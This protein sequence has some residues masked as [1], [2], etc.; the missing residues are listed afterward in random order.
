MNIGGFGPAAALSAEVLGGLTGRAAIDRVRAIGYGAIGIPVWR[1][2]FAPDSLGDSGSRDLAA[3]LGK[4]DLSVSWLST[5]HKGRFTVA[6]TVQEDVER[7]RS[8]CALSVKLR[9][10]LMPS[11]AVTATLGPL[12]SKD[13]PAAANAREA[14]AAIAADADA[15]GTVVALAASQG[16]EALVAELI[17]G[18]PGAPLGRLL[19]PGMLLFAGKDPVDAASSSQRVM[20][21]RASDSGA[22]E[23]NLAPGEGRV[24]WRDFLAA[25]GSRD[26]HGY[27][28]VEFAPRG[29]DAERAA[30]ALEALRRSSI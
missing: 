17:A 10:P 20:A 9:T 8:V 27:A 22:E 11:I 21:V 4:N 14:L 28:T 13:S 29:N 26:Y 2:D 16:E 15:T 24:P 23:T 18:F 3:Y 30:R 6:A 12:G 5:G 19:D 25:L 1:R 7:I